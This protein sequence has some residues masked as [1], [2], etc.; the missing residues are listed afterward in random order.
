M[1]EKAAEATE[2]M[3]DDEVSIFFFKVI[4][5]FCDIMSLCGCYLP[6]NHCSNW[7]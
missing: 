1:T 3:E 4:I 6:F 2:D 7:T 5:Y